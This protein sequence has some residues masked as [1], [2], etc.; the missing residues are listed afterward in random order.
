MGLSRKRERELKRLK[1]NAEDL[2]RDQRE[3]LEHANKV[4][5]DASRQAANFAREEVRPAVSSGASATRSAA[6]T[7]KEK[8]VDE[9]FPS[10]SSALASALAVLEV[11]KHPDVRAA[12]GRVSKGA[13][14]VGHSAQVVPTKS[15]GPGRFILIGVGLVAF[16]GVAY[17]A[18][19]T[20]RADDSLWVEDDPEVVDAP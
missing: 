3:V 1:S 9:L 8:F 5:R 18:W 2:L 16:A 20:L 12:L 17:A 6:H 15:A 11:A 4:I 19:Q 13:A 7:A 10:I 14:A